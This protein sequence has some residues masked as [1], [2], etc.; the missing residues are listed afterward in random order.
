MSLIDGKQATTTEQGPSVWYQKDHGS[1]DLNTAIAFG[2]GG[3][4][5]YHRDE[6][7]AYIHG[8]FPDEEAA[9]RSLDA[10]VRELLGQDPTNFGGPA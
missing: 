6:T 3:P 2:W 9:K 8:P 10:Y 4:G 5:W 1:G 7:D